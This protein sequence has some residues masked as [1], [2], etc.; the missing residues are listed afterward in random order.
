VGGFNGTMKID[1]MRRRGVSRIFI[2][3]KITYV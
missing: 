2:D 3:S 1:K